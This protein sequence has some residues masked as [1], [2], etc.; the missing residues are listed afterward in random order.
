[1]SNFRDIDFYTQKIKLYL[2]LNKQ[3]TLRTAVA[4]SRG[5]EF[6]LLELEP[7]LERLLQDRVLERR[8]V[9]VSDKNGQHHIMIYAYFV[10]PQF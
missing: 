1:M 2:K 4:I 9:Q 5:T 10:I 8:K 6:T 3:L 7:I